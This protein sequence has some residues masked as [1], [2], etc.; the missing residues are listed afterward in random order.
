MYL[1]KLARALAAFVEWAV[2]F[3]LDIYQRSMPDDLANIRHILR[4]G[5]TARQG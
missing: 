4:L 3:K 5:D 2:L 1:L